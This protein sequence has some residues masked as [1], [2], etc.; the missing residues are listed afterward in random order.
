MSILIS[1][2]KLSENFVSNARWID[3]WDTL[4][5]FLGNF[6][7]KKRNDYEIFITVGTSLGSHNL[8]PRSALPFYFWTA[9]K[10]G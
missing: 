8:T 1:T 2:L 10:N 3:F 5:Y 4:A 7:R 6:K 9:C